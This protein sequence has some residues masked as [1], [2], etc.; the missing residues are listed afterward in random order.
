[1][2]PDIF[3]M[4][5]MEHIYLLR[6]SSSLLKAVKKLQLIIGMVW[7]TIREMRS[8]WE[9]PECRFWHLYHISSKLTTTDSLCNEA[10]TDFPNSMSFRDIYVTYLMEAATRYVQAIFQKSRSH[11]IESGI[12]FR[13]DACFRRFVRKFPEYL[14]LGIVD[15]KGNLVK[16]RSGSQTSRSSSVREDVLDA[17]VEEGIG[18]QIL[19][20]AGV[21]LTVERPFDHRRAFA[22]RTVIAAALFSVVGVIVS[23]VVVLLYFQSYFH[24]RGEISRRVS[25]WNHAR[26]NFFGAL[27][28]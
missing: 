8:F 22:F 1:M 21:R 18:R 6:E 20:D 19:Y 9:S 4:F 27:L 14:R 13:V 5:R 2:L 16:V 24:P 3:A 25:F 7:D 12:D 17:G 28:S 10:I 11:M 15:T 23:Y 26:V